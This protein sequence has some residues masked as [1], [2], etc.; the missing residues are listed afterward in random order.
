MGGIIMTIEEAAEKYEAN[1]G[2]QNYVPIEIEE[3]FK[4]GAKWIL[5]KASDWVGDNAVFDKFGRPINSDD[6]RKTMER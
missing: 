1:I 2:S 4:A 5:E 3:A 6:F